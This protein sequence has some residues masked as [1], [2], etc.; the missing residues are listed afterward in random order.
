MTTDKFP[1]VSVVVPVYNMERYLA[2]T[3]ASIEK[4]EYAPFEVVIVNDGSKDNSVAIA[5]TFVDKHSESWR[6]INKPNGGVSSARNTGIAAAKGKYIM[7]FDSD[8][9]ICPLY[10]AHAV[11]IMEADNSV[12]GV[13]AEADFFDGREGRWKLPPISTHLLARKNMIDNSALYRKADWERVGGYCETIKTREDWDF[14]ISILK[15]GGRIVRMPEVGFLYRFRQN[16]KRVTNRNL[17]P[18]VVD[19]VNERHA[20]FFERELGGRLHHHRSWSR[21][22]NGLY[23]LFHPRRVKIAD[24]FQSLEW[25]IKAMPRYFEY[26]K[27]E[28]IRKQR[29]ELRIMTLK[30]IQVVVKSFGKAN[31]INRIAYGLLRPSKACRSYRYA[32]QL[33]AVGIPSP[34]PVAFYNERNGL[35]FGRS[36]YISLRSGCRHTFYDVIDD[37]AL[38]HRLEYLQE[39]GRRTAQLHEAGFYPLDYSGGN[40]LLDWEND[41]VVYELVDL[42]RMRTGKVDL[43]LGCCGFERLNVEAE[44]LDI[45]AEAYAEARGFEVKQCQELVRRYRWKKHQQQA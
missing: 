29:N 40:I 8:N 27:G 22:L 38:P 44:A 25:H 17:K 24:G 45:M 31:F 15:D 34:R 33:I 36:Y 9:I 26:G 16:S 1:L 20:E 35:L 41:K 42:N 10:I 39:V 14:W 11:E 12:M 13:A 6:L 3:L 7:P 18:L 19:K 5:Q 21:F 43:D 28:V 32:E 30:D 2:E 4:I 37:Q 23:R